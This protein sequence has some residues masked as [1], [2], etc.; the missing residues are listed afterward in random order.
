MS[1]SKS[2]GKKSVE[3]FTAL[4]PADIEALL[5]GEPADKRAAILTLAAMC[6]GNIED[7]MNIRGNADL[8]RMLSENAA[9]AREGIR[10]M[11][12]GRSL[13][14]TYGGDHLD[15][16]AAKMADVATREG[17]IS[18]CIFNDVELTVAPGEAPEVA[19]ARW[20]AAMDAKIKAYRASLEGRAARAKQD[21]EDA[22]YQRRHDAS[23][24]SLPDRFNGHRAALTWMMEYADNSDRITIKNKDYPSV[25][26]ACEASGYARNQCTNLPEAAYQDPNTMARYVM[27]QA[28]DGMYRGVIH[29]GM[30]LHTG[31]RALSLCGVG[32]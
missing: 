22:E 15:N 12:Q 30:V 8:S 17:V 27:G 5:Q 28:L 2:L 10:D 20:H 23:V 19:T 11:E 32:S 16:V 13:F 7:A 31:K 21:A 29:S 9:L 1:K 18:Y 14:R 4:D 24:A 26:A 6:R 3:F 25:I